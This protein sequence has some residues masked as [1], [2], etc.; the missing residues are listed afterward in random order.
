MTT[1]PAGLPNLFEASCHSTLNVHFP[2]RL[3]RI[4][5]KACSAAVDDRLVPPWPML[6]TP[7]PAEAE[8][9]SP[10]KR[11]AHTI[12][13]DSPIHH[14]TAGVLE[15]ARKRMEDTSATTLVLNFLKDLLGS[16]VL[17][18]LAST[19]EEHDFLAARQKLVQ[20]TANIK[21]LKLENAGRGVLDAH[22]FC[23]H[24]RR[25]PMAVRPQLSYFLCFLP[26]EYLLRFLTM[27][28][29]LLQNYGSLYSGCMPGTIKHI[30]ERVAVILRY[31]DENVQFAGIDAY[32]KIEAS[33]AD[34][35]SP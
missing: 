20:S 26:V 35:Q 19:R 6:S 15:E 28:P 29:G 34:G 10:S 12:A 5:E 24:L 14:T 21:K 3:L 17:L 4:V 30:E 9:T 27:L 13:A 16:V 31:I 22:V 18:G 8:G 32:E 7:F 2:E 33:D 23:E 1:N 11:D 25:G